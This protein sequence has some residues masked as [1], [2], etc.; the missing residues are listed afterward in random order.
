MTNRKQPKPSSA[1][2]ASLAITGLLSLAI[3]GAIS[4]QTPPSSTSTRIEPVVV[5]GTRVATP[6]FDTAG[7]IDRVDGSDVRNGRLQVNLSESVGAVPGL[8][9]RDRQNY[10]QDVQLSVRGFG[11]RSSFG[12]RGVR[13]YVDDIPATLPDGQ[14]QITH[15]DLGSV[16]HIEVLRGPFSALYGN[17]SGGV[18]AVYTEDGQAPTSLTP[19]FAIGSYRT[20]RSGLKFSGASGP[21]DAVVDVNRF[22][23]QGYREH[24]A[25]QRNLFNAKLGIALDNAST[26]KVV[27]NS[28]ELGKADDPLGLTH[29]AFDANPRGV[30]AS[31]L[32]FNTRKA[33]N[34]TQAGLVYT[35]KLDDTNSVRAVVYDGHRNTIQFQAIPVAAQTSPLSAGGVI[36]LGRD[37][38]GVDLRWTGTYGAAIGDAIGGP[39]TIVAGLAYDDLN[40]LRR[41]YRNFV[42]TT[43]GVQGDLR[44]DETNAVSDGDAYLQASWRVAPRWTVDAG[45]RS[46]SVRFRS[47]DHYVVTG[48]PDDSG[49]VRFSAV[50]PV[51]GVVY[52]P[53][54]D[55]RF[56]VSAGR[57]F[58]T[59]T[60]NEL[61]YRPNGA[62]GLNFALQAVH[63][64]S[65]EAGVK[66]RDALVGTLTAAVFQVHTQD[67][68]VTQTNVG[69]RAT[70]QNA[71][72]TRRNGLELSLKRELFADARMQLAYTLLDARYR[73][74]FLTCTATPCPQPTRVVPAGN[75][76][77]GIARSNFYGELAWEPATGWRAGIEARASSRVYVDDLNSDAAPSYAI[78]SVRAGYLMRWER[79]TLNGFARVDNLFARRYAGSV[80][81]NESNG[82]YFEPAPGRTWTAGMSASVPL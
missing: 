41:G 40:E 8:V 20:A 54:D 60:L 66:V 18:V 76:I 62:S 36:A 32:Q 79:W 42:G 72:D 21:V 53:A 12:V 1:A 50:L 16:D 31:A 15:V 26:L 7:A 59:P 14:G 5:T 44:R 74:G 27:V 37:Y 63:S 13:L 75:R 77:P 25:A 30:D 4:A 47:S 70:F 55:L 68:L 11:A 81:V 39:L 56:Y 61:S 43:L 10:A 19:N 3:S 80:I 69:G 24:S 82:R 9:A 67:E 57:G 28:I 64:T 29:A 46:S 6:A 49:N 22:T 38:H 33:N 65:V 48:N 78:A 52:A 71:G 35:R 17:S 34:Q 73:S 23:T 58:E 2:R 51:A 45:A